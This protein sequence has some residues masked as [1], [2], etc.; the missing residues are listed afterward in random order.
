MEGHRRLLIALLVT[1]VV[2]VGG[3][4]FGVSSHARTKKDA[5]PVAP[6]VP[7]VTAVAHTR[8]VGV[9]LVGLGSVTPLSTVTVKTRVDG[10]LL[11]VLY[12]EGQT[13]AAGALLAEIDPRPFQVQ[14][15]QAEGQFARD[16]ALLTNAALDLQ[17]FR[18]LAAQDSIATQQV[19]TQ[20]S[21]VRQ[22][23]GAVKTDQAQVDSAKLQLVYCRI[24]APSAGRV[25]LRL[26]DPG[27]IVHAADPGGLIVITQLQPITVVFTIPEDS[28][29]PVTE[30]LGR[31]E[32]M[33]VEA[34]DREVIHKLADGFLLSVDNQIDQ[35]T[36][37]LRLKAQF[38]NARP[39]LF[40]NQFVNARL[41][42]DVK[43]GAVVVPAVAVQRST[44]GTFVFVVKPDRTVTAR[45]VTV[46]VT[47]RDD[48][49]VEKGLAAGDAVVVD[50]VDRLREGARVSPS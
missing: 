8:D 3:I 25:G 32:R 45:P 50:G 42:I 9:Y 22:Y 4:A 36:G 33:P 27:N 40:P 11:S 29:S 43:R 19:D 12:K 17:R 10:Q 46:S 30:N 26:V 5:K 1:A 48:I 15:E 28:I 49:V 23:E 7:V 35:T 14:L 41:L 24:T 16:Q 34:W 20:A 6:P 38:D 37:T 18:T 13:V 21:L 39:R 2:A 31:G 47:D 44:R